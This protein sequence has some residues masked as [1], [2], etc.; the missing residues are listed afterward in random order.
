MK[1][2]VVDHQYWLV[3]EEVTSKEQDVCDTF[4]DETSLVEHKCNELSIKE[5]IS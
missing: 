2:L 3:N 5:E 4:P 1:N